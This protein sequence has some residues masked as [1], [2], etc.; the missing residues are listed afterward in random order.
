MALAV[1]ANLIED[2][3]ARD[4]L[5]ACGR[6]RNAWRGLSLTA[7]AKPLGFFFLVIMGST[8]QL[9]MAAVCSANKLAPTVSPGKTWEGAVAGMLASFYVAG[10]ALLVLSRFA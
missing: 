8:Q 9:T 4:S 1:R 10:S 2:L 3:E 6:W 7:F 5:W